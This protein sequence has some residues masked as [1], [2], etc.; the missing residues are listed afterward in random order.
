VTKNDAGVG[1]GM[2]EGGIEEMKRSIGT[3]L[4]VG[5]STIPGF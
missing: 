4:M 5:Y 3:V 1:R 2:E